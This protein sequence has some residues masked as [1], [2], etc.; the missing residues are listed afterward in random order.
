MSNHSE[1]SL[2]LYHG[3]ARIV[4]LALIGLAA[5]LASPIHAQEPLT[6][7]LADGWEGWNPDK[8][9]RIMDSMDEAIA[10]YNQFGYFPKVL[11]AADADPVWTPT[12][13]GNFAGRI[14]F[15]GQV[16]V[17]TAIH[18]VSHTLG[19]GTIT[20]WQDR[21]INNTWT[22]EFAIRQIREWDG[23]GALPHGDAQHYWPYG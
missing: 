12:A 5:F 14:Q 17:R 10:L 8:R 21:M 22:G 23:P 1:N 4:A 11:T 3:R 9:Q 13:D 15:G 7:R 2:S 19:T 16:G 18:E 6:Y 20:A